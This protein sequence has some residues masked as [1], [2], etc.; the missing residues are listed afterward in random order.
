M[1]PRLALAA[2]LFLLGLTACSTLPEP[3][4]ES[5]DELAQVG[6]LLA[7]YRRLAALPPDI[8]NREF[9]D[10]VA[11]YEKTPDDDNRLRLVMAL[12][13][14]QAPW[15]DDARALRLLGMVE[16]TADSLQ[17]APRRDL[18][19]VLASLVGDRL[20]LQREE[21]HRCE[22]AQ[23]QKSNALREERRKAEALQHKLD[24]A[25]EECRK[26]SILQQKL[27]ELRGIDRELR[28]R[29]APRRSP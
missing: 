18:A 19:A 13:V 8:Q 6:G 7:Y 2:T 16:A 25:R 9:D 5:G 12:L 23:Q 22:V 14:P 24:A 29:P 10:A 26:A 4:A 17:T 20:H 27:D 21:R 3:F 1:K 15:R 11:A 28:K